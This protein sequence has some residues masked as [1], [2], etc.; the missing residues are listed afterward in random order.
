[1]AGPASGRSEA[2]LAEISRKNYQEILIRPNFSEWRQNW[3]SEIEEVLRYKT[4]QKSRKSEQ[5]SRESVSRGS[6]ER[7]I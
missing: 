5:K 1:M 2:K 6:V 4:A 3:T 7:H